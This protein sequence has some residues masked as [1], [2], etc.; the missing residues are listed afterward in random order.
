MTMTLTGRVAATLL[1]AVVAAACG[2]RTVETP[3]QAP[4]AQ[5]AVAPAVAPAADAIGVPECDEYLTKYQQCVET[6]VPEMAR[7]TM[8]QSFDQTRAAWKQAAANAQAKQA[9]AAGCKQALD[10]AKQALAAYGCT[11]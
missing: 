11:W 4:A 6:K 3:K 5:Q 9:L 7:A 1:A 8:K 10:A 2:G